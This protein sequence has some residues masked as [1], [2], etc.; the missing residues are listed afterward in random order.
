M[1]KSNGLGM[2]GADGSAAGSVSDTYDAVREKTWRSR[3]PS[4]DAKQCV[5]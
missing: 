2:K 5:V 3:G 1:Q 4:L